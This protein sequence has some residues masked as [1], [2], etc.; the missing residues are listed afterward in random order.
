MCLEVVEAL[1]ERR[2]MAERKPV[3]MTESTQPVTTAKPRALARRIIL[4]RRP[5]KPA[6]LKLS[7]ILVR[8]A[9]PVVPARLLVVNTATRM[10]EALETLPSSEGLQPTGRTNVLQDLQTELRMRHLTDRQTL[11]RIQVQAWRL[12]QARLLLLAR[13]HLASRLE[14]KSRAPPRRRTAASRRSNSGCT[15]RQ[16]ILCLCPAS[17][18][19]ISA[20]P[21]IHHESDFL[22]STLIINIALRLS[23]ILPHEF[24]GIEHGWAVHG[25]GYSKSRV[26]G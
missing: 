12:L 21:F 20:P 9:P 18:W 11:L 23:G 4:F 14:Q 22:C 5:A 26:V 17:H 3:Q 25:S 8:L 10:L 2:L 7:E 24:I 13:Q 16:R 15:L 1:A 19:F 6:V